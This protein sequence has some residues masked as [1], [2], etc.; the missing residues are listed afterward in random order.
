MQQ[1]QKTPPEHFKYDFATT[2]HYYK[3]GLKAAE[4]EGEEE[5]AEFER[6][7]GANDLF[8]LL[9]HILKRKDIVCKWL[10]ER[11]REVQLDPNG[12][13]DLWAREHYKSTIITFGLTI[14]DI[15]ND[16]EITI[17]IFSH[18]KAIAR[19]FVRQIKT[20]FEG[21]DDL[22][23]LWP[24]IFYKEGAKGAKRWSIDGGICVKRKSNPKEATVEGHGLVDGMPTGKHFKGRVY[25]DVVTKEG[26]NTPEQI[27]KTTEARQMSDNLGAKGGW[28]RYIGTRYH[29]FDDY[30]VMMDDKIVIPRLRAA[31]DD[32]T[33]YGNA[34]FMTQDD[35]D[36]KRRNQGPFIFGSQMLL[37]PVADKAM[38]FQLPWIVK[39]DTEYLAAM[40]SLWRF[41]IVDPAGGKQ[42][43]NNDYT[44]FFVI[45][46]GLDGMY[47]VLDIRRDRMKLTD[48]CDTLFELHK[49]WKPGLVA[50]EEYGMQA[51][52]EHIEYVQG[53]DLYKFSI[54]PLGGK[55]RKELR[56][57]RL[58]ALFE[59]G[60]KSIEDGGD[61]VAKSRIILPTSCKQMDYQGR[62]RD[63]VADFIQEEYL[64]FPVFK[65][66]DMLDCLARIVDLE[67]KAL[68]QKPSIVPAQATSLKVEEGLRKLGQKGTGSW[69]TA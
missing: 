10:F 44:T 47:R 36:R 14:Q 21:N 33:E 24:D 40:S 26:V 42:R 55:M 28:E 23:R 50:Y 9:T 11:C 27:Q 20:E 48:R 7:H 37:N 34:V 31:T 60:Y 4:A 46:Y 56:I 32:G 13:L 59:N 53:R 52:I 66:D 43:K 30:S 5:L 3:Q 67:K 18:T 57:L 64:A 16:P 62:M 61:G 65:H 58:V 22:Y 41:I 51:D 15:I 17:G 63:L 38:G 8:F 29:L 1:T 6:T 39:A 68:I 45:G 19:D 35:L 54:T 49:K 12:H 25:D 69:V 2:L